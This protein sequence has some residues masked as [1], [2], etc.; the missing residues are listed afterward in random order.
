MAQTSAEK[1][2][3]T[4]IEILTAKNCLFLSKSFQNVEL[5]R[6]LQLPSLKHYILLEM[7]SVVA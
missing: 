2:S 3:P 4:S 7:N 6:F 5:E 1:S